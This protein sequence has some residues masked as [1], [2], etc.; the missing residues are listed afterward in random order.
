MMQGW[1]FPK[2]KRLT[3]LLDL[4]RSPY[5]ITETGEQE[6]YAELS[7]DNPSGGFLSFKMSNFLL[8][9]SSNSPQRPISKFMSCFDI[10]VKKHTRDRAIYLVSDA[11]D[12]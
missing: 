3:S 10:L 5:F 2:I 12:A 7:P 8:R 6:N 11:N 4:P 1:L 9:Y